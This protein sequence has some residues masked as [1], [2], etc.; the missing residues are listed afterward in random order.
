MLYSR[1]QAIPAPSQG[2]RADTYGGKP[3]AESGMKSS[4][5]SDGQ[6]K[7]L[8]E[9]NLRHVLIT[10]VE[11]PSVAASGITMR[12]HCAKALDLDSS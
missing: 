3:L 10:S 4:D 8:T 2:F 7:F 1:H 5:L 9:D 12:R 11:S 6:K